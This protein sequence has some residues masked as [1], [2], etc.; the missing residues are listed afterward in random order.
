MQLISVG[1][2]TPVISVC[3]VYHRCVQCYRNQLYVVAL[4]LNVYSQSQLLYHRNWAPVGAHSNS[5]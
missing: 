5:L 4:Q 2:L 3:V 1:F